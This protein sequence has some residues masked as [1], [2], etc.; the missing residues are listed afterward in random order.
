MC[1]VQGVPLLEGLED[2]DVNLEL[3]DLGSL[4]SVIDFAKRFRASG[5]KIDCLINNAGIIHAV[6]VGTRK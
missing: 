3:V 1:H 2:V 4:Q 6:F 5:A